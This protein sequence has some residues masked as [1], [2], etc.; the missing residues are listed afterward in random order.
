MNNETPNTRAQPT[1]DPYCEF[2]SRLECTQVPP[3]STSVGDD[4]S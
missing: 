3:Q 2:T 1:Q 4:F